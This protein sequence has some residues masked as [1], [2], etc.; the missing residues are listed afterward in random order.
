M[1]VGGSKMSSLNFVVPLAI[2]IGGREVNPMIVGGFVVVTILL[3]I[4]RFM[5]W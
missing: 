3:T 5:E 4:K 1:S 2:Q